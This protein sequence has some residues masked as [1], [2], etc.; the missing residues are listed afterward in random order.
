[1]QKTKTRERRPVFELRVFARTLQIQVMDFS[2]T[3]D[4]LDTALGDPRQGL[5][6]EVFRFASRITPLINVDLLI[7]DDDGRTLL[8]WRDDESFGQGWHIPGGIIRYKETAAHRIRACARQELGAEVSFD[9]APLLVSE[10]IRPCR[11]RG[12][13]ISLLYRCRLTTPPEPARRSE[14]RPSPGAWQWHASCPPDLLEAQAHYA[15]FF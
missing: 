5:P 8:T 13:F 14:S 15:P 1:L 3:I 2:T 6:E 11:D 10:T 9:A 12:H 7:Q 4:S